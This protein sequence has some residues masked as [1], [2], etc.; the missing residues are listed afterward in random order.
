MKKNIKEEYLQRLELVKTYINKI[1]EI[2]DLSEIKDTIKEIET[3]I[4]PT[5]SSE[6]AYYSAASHL[7]GI[8]KVLESK[9]EKYLKANSLSKTIELFIKSNTENKTNDKVD[10]KSKINETIENIEKEIMEVLALFKSGNE[11]EDKFLKVK[12]KLYKE[13]YELIKLEISKF[14]SYSLYNKIFSNYKNILEKEVT[15]ELNSMNLEDSK[16]VAI[17]L[18]KLKLD[19]NGLN[20]SYASLD[21]VKVLSISKNKEEVLK[22]LKELEI[23]LENATA[24]INE[25]KRNI[26]GKKDD[27]NISKKTFYNNKKHTLKEMVKSG[28]LSLISLAIVLGI[29]YGAFRGAKASA[30]EKKYGRID[31][32]YSTLDNSLETGEKYY[33]SLDKNNIILTEYT[34]WEKHKNSFKRQVT[35]YDLTDLGELSIR[36]SVNLDVERLGLKGTT[37]KETKDY[38]V[39]DDLYETTYKEVV[40]SNVDSEDINIEVSKG[41]TIAMTFLLETFGVLLYWILI[42]VDKWDTE[43]GIINTRPFTNILT[44]KNII[45]ETS[46]SKKVYKKDLVELKRIMEETKQDYENIKPL[47]NEAND[48]IELLKLDNE[49]DEKVEKI[50]KMLLTLN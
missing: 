5:L 34:P 50:N 12:N 45:R 21:L 20:S 44:I 11:T 32:S 33:S 39:L 46:A 29:G 2:Y 38:L 26:E 41:I 24:K 49:F 6:T 16:N 40:I 48:R 43:C 31:I 23:D 8:I 15:K 27:I 25:D 30:T 1:E 18:Q 14:N 7:D 3:G 10:N 47:I 37:E 28:S 19:R 9:Y 35:T 4:Y 13:I 22:S 17:Y 36:D 42:N